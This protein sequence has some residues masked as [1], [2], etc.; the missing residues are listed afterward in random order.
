MC[1][2]DVGGG[3]GKCFAIP[4]HACGRKIFADG[5]V[6]VTTAALFAERNFHCPVVRQVELTPGAVVK[7][8]R[9]RARTIARFGQ[10]VE[11][12]CLLDQSPWPDR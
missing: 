3:N 8:R 1:L 2:S 12:Y 6:T 10:I 4:A 5:F 7:I 9:S 11:K